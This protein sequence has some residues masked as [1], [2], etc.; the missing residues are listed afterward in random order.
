[1]FRLVAFAPKAAIEHTTSQSYLNLAPL[2]GAGNSLSPIDLSLSFTEI[3]KYFQKQ[4]APVKHK[5]PHSPIATLLYDIC[6][7]HTAE[8]VSCTA[9]TTVASYDYGWP[10]SS[11]AANPA[12]WRRTILPCIDHGKSPSILR[13][14]SPLRYSALVPLS[15]DTPYLER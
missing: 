7:L 8:L 10:Q 13:H 15:P 6:L 1:M 4:G 9:E 2:A 5:S 12:C 11:T 3:A 14:H